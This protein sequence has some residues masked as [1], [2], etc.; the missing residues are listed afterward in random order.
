MLSMISN[1]SVER[2]MILG[3]IPHGT[4]VQL[5]LLEMLYQTGCTVHAVVSIP[6][7]PVGRI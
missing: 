3:Y 7:T 2:L 6:Y 5:G 1:S 4:V